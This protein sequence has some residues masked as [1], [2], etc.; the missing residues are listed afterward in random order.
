[1]SFFPRTLAAPPLSPG[2]PIEWEESNCLLCGGHQWSGLVEAPDASP[3]GDNRDGGLWFAIVQCQDCGLCFTNPRPSPNSIGQFYPPGGYSP[4]ELGKHKDHLPGWLAGLS[5]R[6]RRKDRQVL[7]WYGRGRLLDFGCGGGSFLQRMGGL[8][9]QVT[10]LDISAATVCRV[11][12]DLGLRVLVGS[13]PHPEL[14]PES[15]DVITMWQSLEHVHQPREVLQEAHQLLTADG[16][17]LVAVPNIDSLGF[18][19]FGRDWYG[20]DLPRHLTHFTPMTLSL[21]LERA[22][23]RIGLI[24]MVRH[25]KW[26][27]SSAVRAIQRRRGPYWHRWLTSKPA[28]RLSTWYSYLTRQADCIVATAYK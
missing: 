17:L 4:R 9:W 13:L 6:R 5:K 27:R 14:Q 12:A 10:G 24:Q 2:L 18:R 26:L 28:A 8:G 22:G 20:L 7:A 3:A 11:R 15:F 1:M 21:M 19:W 23:F 25:P 16:K